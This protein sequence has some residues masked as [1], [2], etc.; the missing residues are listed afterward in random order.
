MTSRWK[1]ADN[2]GPVFSALAIFCCHW[3]STFSGSWHGY[4]CLCR[5]HFHLL[6]YPFFR[7]SI[8]F[9]CPKIGKLVWFSSLNESILPQGLFSTENYQIIRIGFFCFGKSIVFQHF[10]SKQT[11]KDNDIECKKINFI[12]KINYQFYK[13]LVEFGGQLVFR[14]VA[15]YCNIFLYINI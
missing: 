4:W 6:L 1:M 2:L 5:C 13:F 11:S 15:F 14:G 8:H 7:V 12:N 9:N 3:G 10:T